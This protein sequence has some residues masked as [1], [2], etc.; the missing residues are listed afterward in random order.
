MTN[1]TLIGRL[2]RSNISDYIFGCEENK[3]DPASFGRMVYIKTNNDVKVYGLIYNINILD[4]GI[5]RQLST[6]KNV[7][8]TIIA[9]T[10][11]NRSVTFEI[12]VLIVGYEKDDKIVHLPPP[13]PPLSLDNIFLCT[14]EDI[15]KFNGN[16]LGYL[17]QITKHPEA[18]VAELLAVHFMQ[19]NQAH[20]ELND[21]EWI[22]K[23]SKELTIL[24][25]DDYNKL[26]DVFGAISA[27]IPTLENEGT[28]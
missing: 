26:T 5:V 4:D 12:S 1:N 14:N 22:K 27:A 18:P 19:A 7:P 16:M 10:K 3:I 15:K 23:A 25:R 21:Y 20:I 24:L 17:R 11:E 9:D 6:A 8:E 13:T 2:I 28:E